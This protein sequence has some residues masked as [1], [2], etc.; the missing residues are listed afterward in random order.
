MPRYSCIFILIHCIF[1]TQE[2]HLNMCVQL[3]IPLRMIDM[4]FYSNYNLYTQV[5]AAAVRYLFQSF[6]HSNH[7][8]L[9]L[10][11]FSIPSVRLSLAIHKLYAHKWFWCAPDHIYLVCMLNQ[12]STSTSS[13]S[14][15]VEQSSVFQMDFFF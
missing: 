12:I 9:S 7:V 11:L 6:F 5:V 13:L 2:S 14:L 1:E 4:I 10:S 15:V 3:E 8:I